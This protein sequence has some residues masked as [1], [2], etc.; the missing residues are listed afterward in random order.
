[1]S[2]LVCVCVCEHE[3]PTGADPEFS[4]EADYG[5]RV[6]P[7]RGIWGGASSGVLPLVRVRDEAPQAESFCTFLY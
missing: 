2:V 5:E 7:K 1:M 6:E 3:T 4:K